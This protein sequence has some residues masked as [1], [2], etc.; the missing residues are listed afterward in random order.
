[1]R[2]VRLA[3]LVCALLCASARAT[4]LVAI[5]SPQQLLLGADSRVVDDQR[6]PLH[7]A[8][9][10]VQ[11]GNLFLAFSGLAEDPATG[12]T[13]AALARESLRQAGT[14]GERLAHFA[15]SARAPL[16]R[17]VTGLASAAP[18]QF[19]RLQGGHPVLQVIFAQVEAGV[20]RLGVAGF[21]MTGDGQVEASTRLI[22]D[23]DDGRGPRIIYAGQQQEIRQYLGTHHDWY[24]QDAAGLIRELITRESASGTGLVGT[25]VDILAL[26][27]A[28]ARWLQRKPECADLQALP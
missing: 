15:G 1:M 6:Q 23:G 2:S 10:I 5:W 11:Q 3:V 28:R 18:A 16:Q 17:A 12:F 14:L 25:P 22:A 26:G 8:C 20:P 9:K 4:T 7:N 19:R 21:T 27:P 24:A 13:A